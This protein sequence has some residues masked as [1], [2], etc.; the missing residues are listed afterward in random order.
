MSGQ[1]LM[2]NSPVVTGL[3]GLATGLLVAALLVAGRESPQPVSVTSVP[4]ALI[5][6]AYAKPVTV[7]VSGVVP[8]ATTV[9][10]VVPPSRPETLTKTVEV[11]VSPSSAS[12]TS[13]VQSSP[14]LVPTT[15]AKDPVLPE[16]RRS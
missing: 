12:S 2:R 10:D 4:P 6:S 1:A 8:S 13:S 7:T 14:V 15:A 9:T 3:A 5:T 16:V 11:T